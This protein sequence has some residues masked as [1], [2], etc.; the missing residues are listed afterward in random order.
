MIGIDIIEIQRFVDMDINL[1]INK[2]FTD[3]EAAYIRSKHN[4]IETLAGLYAL[5]EAV[6]KALSCGIN[7]NLK[8]IEISHSNLGQ[9]TVNLTGEY[10]HLLHK[11]GYN[12]VNASISHTNLTAV[13]VA[14]L[15]K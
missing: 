13:A 8:N 11:L 5:K 3:N 6:V 7:E 2:V 12:S 10:F 1:L 15:T 14:I 9:P 4:T